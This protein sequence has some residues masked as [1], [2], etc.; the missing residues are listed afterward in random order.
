MIFFW[1]LIFIGSLALLIKGA[2][3]F[4][5]S[6]EKVGLAL[7][8]S[9]FIIGVTIVTIGTSFPEAAISIA[10]TLRGATEVVVSTAIGA[11]LQLT[12]F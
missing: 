3:W 10:A 2:D 12:F 11:R 6:A 9:P 1:I 8:M 7:K 4:V 5:E